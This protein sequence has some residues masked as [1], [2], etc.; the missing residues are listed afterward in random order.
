MKTTD[1]EDPNRWAAKLTNRAPGAEDK[2]RSCSITWAAKQ[3][4]LQPLEWCFFLT[5]PFIELIRH[6]KSNHSVWAQPSANCLENFIQRRTAKRLSCGFAR[7][8]HP[9]H[10]QRPHDFKRTELC[11]RRDAHFLSSSEAQ[12]RTTFTC[13][14]LVSLSGSL[15]QMKCCP[16][17]I[18]P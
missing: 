12:F 10:A 14:A 6:N 3:E 2:N 4:K 11:A 16:S 17:G 1:R 15:M 9:T 8:N 5:S 13:I 7:F 18:T